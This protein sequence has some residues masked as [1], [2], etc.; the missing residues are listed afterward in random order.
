MFKMHHHLK[1]S[2]PKCKGDS[3]SCVKVVRSVGRMHYLLVKMQVELRDAIQ[4]VDYNLTRMP[5][6]KNTFTCISLD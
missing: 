1:D 5:T 4:N 6:Y 3:T 2:L